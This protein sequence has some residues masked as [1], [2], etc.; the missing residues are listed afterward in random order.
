MICLM[1]ETAE[2]KPRILGAI[3]DAIV[4]AMRIKEN[5][6]FSSLPRMADFAVWG[7]AISQALGYEANE[8]IQIYEENIKG[9]NEEVV[10]SHAVAAAVNEFMAEQDTWGGTATE[11]LE[12][13]EKVATDLKLDTKDKGWPKAPHVL[14]RR[15]KE[16]ISNL[17]DVGVN[18]S[19]DRV[20]KR[21]VRLE[22]VPKKA[23]E[24]SKASKDYN[25][26][27]LNTDA[28]DG[29]EKYRQDSVGGKLK[30][31]QGVVATDATDA[32]ITTLSGDLEE[33]KQ[34]P[35]DDISDDPF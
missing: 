17:R 22:R 11:L 25:S 19:F 15:L 30:E 7:E 13:L 34:A 35:W 8:F 9:K 28:T 6:R 27:G 3:F 33:P 16:V 14:T 23:S 26:K 5:I 10:R 29:T 31:N 20:D 2:E 4:G 21:Q 12:N 18:V 24:A 1:S 32:N